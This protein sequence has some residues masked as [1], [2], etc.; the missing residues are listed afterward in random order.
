MVQGRCPRCRRG[1]VFAHPLLSLKFSETNETCACCGLRFEVEPGFF[2]GAMFFSYGITV[3]V[4]IA[5]V[6]SYF[7]FVP[8][9][10]EWVVVGAVGVTALAMSP[11]NFRASRML[12]LYL[13]SGVE[14]E[15]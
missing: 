10:S 15:G 12:M 13:F 6:V 5:L 11:F 7:L 1:A 9:W 8:H 4:V 3:A 14:F 2:W